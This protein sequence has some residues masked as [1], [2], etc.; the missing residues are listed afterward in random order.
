M[1]EMVGAW[2]MTVEQRMG[3]FSE[4]EPEA[5]PLAA[6]EESQ[7]VPRPPEVTPHCLWI[8]VRLPTMPLGFQRPKLKMIMPTPELVLELCVCVLQ[9]TIVQSWQ[10]VSAW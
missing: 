9:W 8:Q 4:A 10:L 3:L 7:P 5:D 2:Q 6:S 1:R